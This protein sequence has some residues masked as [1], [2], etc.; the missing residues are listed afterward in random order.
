[1]RRNLGCV[2]RAGQNGSPR[3]IA[4]NTASVSRD[5]PGRVT[6]RP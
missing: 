3:A 2:D 1:M 6:I 5:P 4:H